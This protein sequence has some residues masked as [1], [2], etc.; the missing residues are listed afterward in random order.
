[1]TGA[2]TQ[3]RTQLNDVTVRNLPIPPSGQVQYPDGKLPGFGVRVSSSGSKTF[4]LTYRVHGQ[5]RRLTLGRYPFTSLADARIKAHEALSGLAKGADPQE[6][7]PG[8]T[9]FMSAVDTFIET[10]C[11]RNNRASTL[12]E[13]ERLLRSVFVPRWKARPLDTIKRADIVAVLDRLISANTPSAAN[14]AFAA[15]RKFFNWCVERGQL[16]VSPC[17]GLRLPAKPSSRDRVLTDK[18]LVRL[19]QAAQSVGYPFGTIFQVLALTGQRRGEVIG[20][21]WSELDFKK[22]IWTLPGSRTK[23]SETHMLPLTPAVIA[24][25]ET[26]PRRSP[27]LVFPARGLPDSPYSGTSKGKRELDAVAALHDWTLH[28]LRRTAATGMARLGV[29]PHLV[30]RILNHV[31]GAF[32]GVAGVYNRFQYLDEMRAALD[33]WTQHVTAILAAAENSTP[34]ITDEPP[35]A[36]RTK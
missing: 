9:G 13:T 23:N 17:N 15:V 20:M 22:G 12:Y 19:W 21:E 30:E 31:S 24:L 18:E 34:R 16:E 33:L 14:H 8:E 4:Y 3:I 5:S 2:R 27:R 28:D 25:L 26:V 35:R 10:H 32:G 6:T 11:R 29:L 36:P 1:M 7:M